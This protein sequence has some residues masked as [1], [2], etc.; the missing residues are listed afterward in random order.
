MLS[1]R[2][3]VL[4]SF[5]LLPF[6]AFSHKTAE[7]FYFQKDCYVNI[8]LQGLFFLKF[9]QQKLIVKSP[10]YV[11]HVYCTISNGSL[12]NL[13][14]N[15]KIDIDL[16]DSNSGLV[17][18]NDN[19]F[20]KYPQMPQFPL[21]AVGDWNDSY[22]LKLTL[23]IPGQII[24]LRPGKL[25]DFK[26]RA[27][28]AIVQKIVAACSQSGNSKFALVTCLRYKKSNTFGA[29]KNSTLSFHAEHMN[30]PP[31]TD[32]NKALDTANQTLFTMPGFDLSFLDL[33]PPADPVCRDKHPGYGIHSSD[34]NSLPEI[35]AGMEFCQTGTRGTD[36]V[37]C[38]QFGLNQ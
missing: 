18:G 34:E 20:T 1:H 27:Q 7:A 13:T 9:E 8:L 31:V 33:F 17:A 38:V 14:A 12:T 11:N 30:I 21:S 2:R 3:A 23:P 36:V 24:P 28:G 16:S 22:K 32:T 35:N 25:D 5:S 6:M 10:Y 37:N 15:P 29:P 26:S 4:K 19:L